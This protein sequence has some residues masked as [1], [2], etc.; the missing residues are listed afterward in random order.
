LTRWSRRCSIRSA[1]EF[2][3]VQ[4]FPA[5][6][7]AMWSL[8]WGLK[9]AHEFGADVAV[10]V[11]IDD[12]LIALQ[13]AT[14]GL[15]DVVVDVTAKAPA[16]FA[17]AVGLARPAGTVVI[18]GTR[19]PLTPAPG[20]SPDI[21]VFKELRIIGALGVDATAYRAALDLLASGRYRFESLPRRCVGLD[22]AA[23]LLATM[24]GEGDEV[25]PVHG[26]LRP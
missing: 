18:A 11:S 4:R 25:P 13:Q 24:G 16:A 26:V 17:Q 19:G 7:P 23:D 14:G 12:P 3:G 1:R 22:G 10:D 9:L 8:C 6:P 20:F 5:P 2:A 21:I 15:A